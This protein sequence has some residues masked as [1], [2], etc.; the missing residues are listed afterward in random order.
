[1]FVAPS[2]GTYQLE[3][4]GAEGGSAW[5][6]TIS[7]YSFDGGKG[8]YAKGNVTLSQGD[9]LFINVGGR[10]GSTSGTANSV[11]NLGGS[12]Y[13]GGGA[14]W[15]APGGGGSSYIGGV[16]SGTTISGAEGTSMPAISGGTET[17]HSGDGYARITKI[18]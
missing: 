16:T 7:P 12:G 18:S 1:M 13:N 3:V 11:Q 15:H 10:G 9:K 5:Y 14:G 4:W 17:G 8:G 6:S 2:A